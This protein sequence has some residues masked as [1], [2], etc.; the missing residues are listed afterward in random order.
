M[1]EGRGVG[2]GDRD[3]GG[4]DERRGEGE[5]AG[6]VGE[7]GRVVERPL[8]GG[9]GVPLP[10]GE[11]VREGEPV[12][13]HVEVGGAVGGD[14]EELDAGCDGEGPGRRRRRGAG[15]HLSGAG[16]WFGLE[17]SGLVGTGGVASYAG[18]GVCWAATE[19][20]EF[21]CRVVAAA[22]GG[23]WVGGAGVLNRARRRRRRGAEECGAI[24]RT[25]VALAP[26]ALRW[27]HVRSGEGKIG[28]T[29]GGNAEHGTRGGGCVVHGSVGL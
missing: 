18:L 8:G 5:E 22:V 17:I 10:G 11:R 7:E 29:R 14:E 4:V 20:A 1:R 6:E 24:R 21:P 9:V 16:G 13:V 2:H 23:F 25:G 26:M 3:E 28:R 12:A 27:R 19:R 15:G